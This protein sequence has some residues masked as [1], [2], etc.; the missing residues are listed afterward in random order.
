VQVREPRCK[1]PESVRKE[2]WAHVLA[3]NLIRTV[4]AQAAV[5][6]DIEPRSISFKG[7][8]QT[9]EAFQPLLAFGAAGDATRRLGL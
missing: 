6:H 4:T 7:A 2:V 8:V 3:Y 9:L 1:A 5:R